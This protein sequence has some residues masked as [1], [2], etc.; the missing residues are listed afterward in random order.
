MC[1]KGWGSQPALCAPERPGWPVEQGAVPVTLG[2]SR[3]KAW[4]PCW[5]DDLRKP[6]KADRVGPGAVDSWEEA[7]LYWGRLGIP[8]GG[9]VVGA[10]G[11]Q[12]AGE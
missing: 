4:S 7:G 9:G 6:L 5:E 3:L 2:P 1:R 12:G 10:W 8:P 11:Q